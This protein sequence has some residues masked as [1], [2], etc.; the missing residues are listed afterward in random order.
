MWKSIWSEP[1][2]I[3]SSKRQNS[4]IVCRT[5]NVNYLGSTNDEQ[6]EETE[7]ESTETDTDPVAYAEFNT[8]K[9]WENYQIDEFSVMAISESFEIKTTKNYRKTIYM[10]ILL[11]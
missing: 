5:T 9:A 1:S 6:Q 10:D 11:N 3:M 2:A 7:I 4:A 8:N